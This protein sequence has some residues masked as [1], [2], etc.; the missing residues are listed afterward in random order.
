[1]ESQYLL[2]LKAGGATYSRGIDLL[3]KFLA[4]RIVFVH[5]RSTAQQGIFEATGNYI[6]VATLLS[7]LGIASNLA[8]L[9]LRVTD[10]LTGLWRLDLAAHLTGLWEIPT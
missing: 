1:M 6:R 7:D 5:V 2:F 9:L 10:Y 8:S 3:G 4:K